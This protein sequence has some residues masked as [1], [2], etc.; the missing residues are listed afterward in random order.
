MALNLIITNIYQHDGQIKIMAELVP[1]RFN[2][3]EHPEKDRLGLASAHASRCVMYEN[4]HLGAAI[5]RQEPIPG[6]AARQAE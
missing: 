1:P 3:R 4:L 5:I 2:V 6:A